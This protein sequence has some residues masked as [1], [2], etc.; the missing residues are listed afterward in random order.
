MSGSSMATPHVA[1]A[2]TLYLSNHPGTKPADVRV[3]LVSLLN[4]E[5]VSSDHTHSGQHPEPLLLANNY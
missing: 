5:A 2:A 4:T 3:T 1:G